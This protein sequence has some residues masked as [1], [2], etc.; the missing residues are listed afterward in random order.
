[1]PKSLMLMWSFQSQKSSQG[2]MIISGNVFLLQE[3]SVLM[4]ISVH[5]LCLSPIPDRRFYPMWPPPGGCSSLEHTWKTIA[6]Y[7]T[8]GAMLGACKPD[9][10]HVRGNRACL[11]AK[12]INSEVQASYV[13]I[14]FSYKV[15]LNTWTNY[16]VSLSSS[17]KWYC[18]KE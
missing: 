14:S 5:D 15:I 16:V 10:G 3:Q 6:Q 11:L 18:C 1:M 7:T 9:F 8:T 12:C 2:H 4:N 17:V 13:L